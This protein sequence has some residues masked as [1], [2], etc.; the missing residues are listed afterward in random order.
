MSKHWI[1]R[2]SKKIFVS[3]NILLLVLFITGCL[4][5]YMP[6]AF[7]SWAGFIG[8]AFPYTLLMVIFSLVFWLI[9]KPKFALLTGIV[10]LLSFKQIGSLF[11]FSMSPKFVNTKPNNALRI[12]SWNIE[13]FNGL[14]SKKNVREDITKAIEK[15]NADVVCLQEFNNSLNTN[16]L[17]LFSKLYPYHYFPGDY[18]RQIA[19]YTSGNVIFSKYPIINSKQIKYPTSESLLYIDVVA[20][21]DTVRIFTTH[22]QS[23]KFNK[24][25]YDEIDKIK[26]QDDEALEASKSIIKKMK[27]A[28]IRRGEQ[29]KIVDEELKKCSYPSVICGDFNDVPNNFTYWKIRGN[30]QDAFIKKGFGIGKTFTSLAPT[31]RIDY[32]LPDNNFDITQFDVAD[33]GL[34][35]HLL[36]ICDVKKKL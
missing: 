35:D 5:P 10:F 29:A 24:K 14:A 13:S 8:I 22:L 15:I 32:M 7:F 31:L 9:V 4:L 26:N 11:G 1:R 18:F 6:P 21:N 16:N 28:F 12:V 17:S 34:S 23:Y 2:Y 30:R 25:N 33:N 36:L 3:L 19:G 20:L 27:L